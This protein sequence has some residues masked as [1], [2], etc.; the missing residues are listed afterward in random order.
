MCYT[1]SSGYEDIIICKWELN[2]VEHYDTAVLASCS[3]SSIGY[4]SL[5]STGYIP[6]FQITPTNDQLMLKKYISDS[7]YEKY[8]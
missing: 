1:I 5:W 7:A 3:C 6:N 8:Q 2:G 4:P